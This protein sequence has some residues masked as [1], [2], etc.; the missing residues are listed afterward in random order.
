MDKLYLQVDVE[1]YIT[2]VAQE[3]FEGH[4]ETNMTMEEFMERYSGE[5][6]TDGRHK[7][8]N[9]EIVSDEGT[10]RSCLAYYETLKTELRDRREKECFSVVN[11]GQVWYDTLSEEQ[12]AEL[13]AWY[14]S[15]LNVTETL[16]LPEKPVW[17]K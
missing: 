3:A 4:M 7:F 14:L 2:A 9:G 8:Y 10:E 17:L 6:V 13:A 1:G 16:E 5:D 15:W 11:R 12:R